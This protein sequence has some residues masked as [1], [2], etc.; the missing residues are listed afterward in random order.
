MKQHAQI[1]GQKWSMPSMLSVCLLLAACGG[2]GESSSTTT[3]ATVAATADNQFTSNVSIRASNGTTLA[4]AANQ[5]MTD[6][7]RIAY[8]V[9]KQ[10]NT[11]L[12]T[13]VFNIPAKNTS[14]TIGSITVVYDTVSQQYQAVVY[15]AAN[16]TVFACSNVEDSTNR[17]TGTSEFVYNVDTGAMQI[18][19]TNQMLKNNATA[20][21]H[22][23]NGSLSG[24]LAVAPLKINNLPVSSQSTLSIDQ[25]TVRPQAIQTDN[26]ADPFV[27]IHLDDGREIYTYVFADEAQNLLANVSHADAES[28]FFLDAT[29]PSNPLPVVTSNTA[30]RIAVSFNRVLLRDSNNRTRTLSGSFSVNK[31]SASLTLD[32]QDVEGTKTP[33]VTYSSTLLNQFVIRNFSIE[34][35]STSESLTAVSVISRGRQVVSVAIEQSANG[36]ILDSYLC[37]AAIKIPCT[38]VTLANNRSEITF[39]NTPMATNSTA[40]PVLL[41][42]KLVGF[43]R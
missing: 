33:F 23:L 17:C 40:K 21:T 36:E 39:N 2:G 27:T 20:L 16:G 41:S 32:Q 37:D 18:S 6:E 19:F 24:S 4:V 1:R 11:V 13:G 31:P 35:S 12:Q 8:A 14:D 3:P 38:G 5:A 9:A 22:T 43:D 15:T 26:A 29:L 42:G 30:A 28:A 7:G 34:P 10:P 25:V